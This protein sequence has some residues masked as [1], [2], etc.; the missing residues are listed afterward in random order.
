MV[1]LQCR[2]KESHLLITGTIVLPPEGQ[3]GNEILKITASSGWDSYF[4]FCSES[5]LQRL[6]TEI[7]C[8]HNLNHLLFFHYQQ[9]FTATGDIQAIESFAH[10][11]NM[12]SSGSRHIEDDS[13]AFIRRTGTVLSI[14]PCFLSIISCTTSS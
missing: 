13:I 5:I 11:T 3:S 1:V 6:F 8:R 7:F 12:P 10:S 2:Q 4:V 14:C 9:A